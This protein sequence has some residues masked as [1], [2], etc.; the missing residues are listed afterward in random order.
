MPPHACWTRC[1]C[2]PPSRSVTSA[3][4]AKTRHRWCSHEHLHVSRNTKVLVFHGQCNEHGRDVRAPWRRRCRWRRWCSLVE[5]HDT[6]MKNYFVVQN[7]T[8]SAYIQ[9]PLRHR[10]S[11]WGQHRCLHFDR[12]ILLSDRNV[13]VLDRARHL[14]WTPGGG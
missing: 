11:C 13:L 2:T 9:L 8:K 5:L 12:S 1:R 10:R 3:P 6:K 4:T 7:C 14:Y